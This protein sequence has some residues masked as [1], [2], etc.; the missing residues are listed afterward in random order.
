MVHDAN[1][2]VNT[3]RMFLEGFDYLYDAAG[4]AMWATAGT[5]GSVTNM[6]GVTQALTARRKWFRIMSRR[7]RSSSGQDDLTR[8]EMTTTPTSA[9]A[10]V[11]LVPADRCAPLEALY[12]CWTEPALMKQ[13]FAPKPYET[14]VVEARCTG[15]AVPAWS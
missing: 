11:E 2:F 13:W 15:R 3:G 1:V 8:G 4:S 9:P 6:N 5:A 14:P 7:G 10:N 12:R